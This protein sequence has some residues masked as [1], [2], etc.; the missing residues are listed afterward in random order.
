ME[1]G[2]EELIGRERSLMGRGG[3]IYTLASLS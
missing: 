2:R 1:G 3:G